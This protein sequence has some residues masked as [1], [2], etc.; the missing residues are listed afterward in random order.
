MRASS[1]R[2]RFGSRLYK[3]MIREDRYYAEKVAVIYRE[4]G[5]LAR[6]IPDSRKKG[7]FEVWRSV[8]KK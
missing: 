8:N 3:L 4:E 6:V 7:N 5:Y 2:K 1:E